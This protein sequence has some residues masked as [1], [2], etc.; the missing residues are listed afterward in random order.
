MYSLQAK[1]PYEE[2]DLSF[3]DVEKTSL[4]YAL[5][6]IFL[7]KSSELFN[8]NHSNKCKF[9]NVIPNSTYGPHDDFDLKTGHVLACLIRKFYEARKKNKRQI[10]LFGSGKPMRE[11]IYSEDVASAVLF[12]L[13][14]NYKDVC[15]IINIG[16]GKE[17]SISDLALKISSIIGFKGKIIFDESYSDGAK[18]KFLNSSQINNYGWYSSTSLE[19]GLLKTFEW[20]KSN[21]E[22]I[23]N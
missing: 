9:I 15:D 22:K 7:T 8:F 4:G 3:V 13:N 1:Q 12:L 23:S 11:F 2:K 14:K 5:S 19:N 10:T 17:I 18:R 6:K 20:F 16:S 21:Y